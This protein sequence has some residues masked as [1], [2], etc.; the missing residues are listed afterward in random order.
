MQKLVAQKNPVLYKKTRRVEQF[1]DRIRR[2]VSNMKKTMKE[3][4][5]IGLAAPQIGKSLQ[6]FVVDAD[7]IKE[8]EESR[9]PSQARYGTSQK[10]QLKLKRVM[11]KIFK[12]KMHDVFINPEILSAPNKGVLMEEGCLSIPGIFGS[13]AR[14]EEITVAA[15]DEHG[16]KFTVK[17]QNLYAHILQHEID[18]LNGVLFIRKAEEGSLHKIHKK[19]HDN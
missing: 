13:V 2:L 1:D 10:I 5:G 12:R 9:N 11:K 16:K 7:H 18:H 8:S 17:A 14:A 4:N 19:S 3:E 15:Q 6:M